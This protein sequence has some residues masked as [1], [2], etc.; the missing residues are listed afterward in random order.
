MTVCLEFKP[1]ILR[2]FEILSRGGREDT[3]SCPVFWIS[4]G[5]SGGG[6]NLGEGGTIF[7]SIRSVNQEN[8]DGIGLI[9]RFRILEWGSMSGVEGPDLLFLQ[10]QGFQFP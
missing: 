7:S 8:L 6:G 3:F 2:E 4:T 1:F 10:K 5:R 9:N